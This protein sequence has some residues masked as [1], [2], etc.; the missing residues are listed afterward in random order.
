MEW[1]AVTLRKIDLLYLNYCTLICG[2]QLDHHRHHPHHYDGDDDDDD[3][4][5][6]YP[7]I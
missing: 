6:L 2:E 5:F 4:I 7:R 1:L 3:A